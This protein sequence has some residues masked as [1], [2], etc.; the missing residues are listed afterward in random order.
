[1]SKKSLNGR[2]ITLTISGW[3]IGLV[4]IAPYVEMLL[5]SLKGK[6]DLLAIP[7]NILPQHA[8]WANFKNIWHQLPLAEFLR[9]SIVVSL[10]ATIL[11]LV[12]AIPAAYFVARNN[13][14]GRNLFLLLVLVTQMFSPTSLV[15]GILREMRSLHLVN[16]WLALILIY[17]AFNMAFSVWILSSFFSSIPAE[18]EEAAWIDGASR[19]KGLIKVILP[20]AIPGVITAFIFTFIAAWNEF[21]IALTL[22]SSPNHQPITVGLESLIGQYQVQWQYLFAG[23]LIAIIPVVILFALIEKWLV[24]GLTAG[25]VK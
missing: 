18:I 16:T 13:F 24:S 9:T 2:K 11:V 25:S 7:T 21:I 22:E 10:S 5:T 8:N 15:I 20:V 19:I 3:I 14:K 6:S 1:M 17:A 23:S 4:F 12:L